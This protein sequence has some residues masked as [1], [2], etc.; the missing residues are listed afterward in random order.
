MI[1]HIDVR[2]VLVQMIA[3]EGQPEWLLRVIVHMVI[4]MLIRPD[5]AIAPVGEETR[6]RHAFLHRTMEEV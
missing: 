2:Q 3:G 1:H 5:A 6:A 4:A